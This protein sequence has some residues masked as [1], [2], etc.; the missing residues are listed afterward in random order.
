M[1]IRQK[2][3]NK[4]Q[5][6]MKIFQKFM[7]FIDFL[8][9]KLHSERYKTADILIDKKNK[10]Q[11]RNLLLGVEKV[12]VL[13]GRLKKKDEPKQLYKATYK[14]N[15]YFNRD[16]VFH[17]KKVVE[18]SDNQYICWVAKEGEKNIQNKRYLR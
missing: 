8:R 14:N 12:L 7:I 17:I 10:K 2:K 16:H 6:I 5:L 9:V 3:L 18:N 4:R 11:L 13:A 1:G 15:P